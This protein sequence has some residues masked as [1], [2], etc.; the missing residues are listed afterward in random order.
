MHNRPFVTRVGLAFALG[1]SLFGLTGCS[2][3]PKVET[4][5]TVLDTNVEGV[6]GHVATRVAQ[7]QTLT[8]KLPTRT[9]TPYGWRL[10]PESNEGS[11]VFFVERM[12]QITDE[13]TLAF[14][15]DS[16]MDLFTFKANKPGA[17]TLEFI[18]DC[19]P[20]GPKSKSMRMTLDVEV[21]NAKSEAMA[22]MK[23]AEEARIA[24]E[25]ALKA[26][27]EAEAIATAD[28]SSE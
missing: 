22:K 2:N 25:E 4:K 10:T 15:D 3:S 5:P 1:L 8:V 13:R 18:Y 7:G 28:T 12:D 19:Q 24:A 27:K 16:A 23:A 6:Q 9:N 26:A 20:G 14:G 11:N 17:Q 21:Y